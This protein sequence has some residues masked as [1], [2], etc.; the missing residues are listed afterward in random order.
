MTPT[1]LAK[2][3]TLPQAIRK[4]TQLAENNQKLVFTNGCFDLLHP[5]HLRYLYEAR[6]LGDFLLVGLNSDASVKRLKG[7]SRPIRSQDERAE[8]LTALCM[9]DGVTIFDEDTP[10]ELILALKPDLLVKGGD[11]APQDIVGGPQVLS[12][13]GQVRSLTLAK[14]FS[15]TNIIEAIAKSCSTLGGQP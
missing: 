13:G 4:R 14:G 11:W 3:L 8:M 12:W 9:I 1:Y 2:F 15:T 5:G 6:A 7:S 10:L